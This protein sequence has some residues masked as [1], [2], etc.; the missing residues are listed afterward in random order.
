MIAVD[1]RLDLPSASSRERDSRCP[2]ARNLIRKLAAAGQLVEEIHSWT[3]S[4]T[5]IHAASEGHDVELEHDETVALETVEGRLAA[6]RKELGVP[7]DAEEL[8]EKRLWL[9]D[10][11]RKIASG[12]PDR[13]WRFGSTSVIPDIKTGWGEVEPEET[14]LQ[15]RGY[16]VLEYFDRPGVQRVIV[17][18]VG[19]HGPK[20][21]PVVYEEPDLLRAKDEWLA[22]VEAC[23]QPDAP[24]VAGSI[25][26]KYCPAKLHCPEAQAVVSQVASLTIHEPGLVVTNEQLV[27]LLDRCSTAEKMV[28]VIR[29]EAR[30][31][32]KD[33]PNSLPGWT[34]TPGRTTS[35][36][37]DLATVF[38]RCTAKGV[39]AEQFTAACSITK[40]D[41][42]DV[43]KA[44]TGLK[45]KALNAVIDEVLE[46]ATEE[47]TS[48][49]VLKRAEK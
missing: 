42:T 39:T 17:A 20:P 14:N 23:K 35:K 33:D 5:R 26:C 18:K 32:L 22:E 13:I 36:V 12:K 1:E 31:R 15:F 9:Y 6:L 47:K 7:D 19:A 25:Q 27:E 16:A 3:E 41:L 40:K 34:L 30:R 11:L 2:G 44:T 24:R 28:A 4:G 48:A 46:G 10:G 29:A 8:I 37:V 38:S 43:L 45:G 21:K 49:P